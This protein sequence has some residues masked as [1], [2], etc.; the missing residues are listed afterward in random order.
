MN[1]L[2]LSK[3]GKV[4]LSTVLCGVVAGLPARAESLK[5]TISTV[6]KKEF[7]FDPNI[8]REPVLDEDEVVLMKPFVVAESSNARGVEAA[9]ASQRIKLSSHFSL[10]DG[11]TLIPELPLGLSMEA[12]PHEELIKTDMVRTIPRWTLLRKSW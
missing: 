7:Q 8:E 12:K 11:G 10:R 9:V 6:L 5:N 3:L 4:T 2:H 1:R